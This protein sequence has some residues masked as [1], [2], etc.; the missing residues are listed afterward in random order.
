MDGGDPELRE[1]EPKCPLVP[2]A[3][4]GDACTDQDGNGDPWPTA[5][6]FQPTWPV[7]DYSRAACRANVHQKREMDTVLVCDVLHLEARPQHRAGPV[8]S[9]VADYARLSVENIKT[10]AT[11]NLWC[12]A[13]H[14]SSTART[15]PSAPP[16]TSDTPVVNVGGANRR[17]SFFGAG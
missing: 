13:G 11:V 7:I 3:H 2:L 16:S 10:V 15:P 4:D 8:V 1:E 12:R 6:D 9:G 17:T 14:F 5:V